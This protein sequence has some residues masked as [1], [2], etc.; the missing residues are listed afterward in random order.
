M[1]SVVSDVRSWGQSRPRGYERRLPKMTRCGRRCGCQ[2]ALQQTAVCL[3]NHLVGEGEHRRGDFEA[4][5]P[6]GLE[7]DH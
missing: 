6:G 3:L 7:I 2:I 4:E 5:R 1:A